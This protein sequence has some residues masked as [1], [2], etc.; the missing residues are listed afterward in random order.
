MTVFRGVAPLDPSDDY[1]AQ[2]YRYVVATAD[3]T[4]PQGVIDAVNA[5]EGGAASSDDATPSGGVTTWSPTL[6]SA[7]FTLS[8]GNNQADEATNNAV[9]VMSAA[10]NSSGLVYAEM[11][12]TNTNG[13]GGFLFAGGIR[14]ASESA[15]TAVNAGKTLVY[16]SGNF[17]KGSY[18][19]EVTVYNSPAPPTPASGDVVGIAINFTA[20]KIW[21]SINNVWTSG[22]PEDPLST[23]AMSW[24]SALDAEVWHWYFNAD[25]NSTNHRVVLNTGAVAFTYTPPAGYGPQP[26]ACVMESVTFTVAR[27]LPESETES[28]VTGTQ[29]P[30]T[31]HSTTFEPVQRGRTDGFRIA[32]RPVL[33]HDALRPHRG[34]VRGGR[35]S[36]H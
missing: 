33:S 13:G 21:F 28:E 24:T 34:R 12:A 30:D 15:T 26:A 23:P 27:S 11:T 1:Y 14:A 6:K 36:G 2:G 5:A 31:E 10:G 18:T 22:D 29:T 9:H 4:I 7:D 32:G 35:H 19:T 20:R 3:V 17:L 16:R 8:S 25:N